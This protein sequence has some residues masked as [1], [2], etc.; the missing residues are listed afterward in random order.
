MDEVVHVAE[1]GGAAVAA[2]IGA[3]AL[4]LYRVEVLMV[5]FFSVTLGGQ[6]VSAMLARMRPAPAAPCKGAAGD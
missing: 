5:V 1:I 3:F 6:F 4:G 2:S